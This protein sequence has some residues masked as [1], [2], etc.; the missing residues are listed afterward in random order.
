M[1]RGGLLEIC[2]PTPSYLRHLASDAEYLSPMRFA[3][4]QLRRIIREEA[5][6]A[7]GVSPKVL[8]LIQKVVDVYASITDAD[9]EAL[10]DFGFFDFMKTIKL[11]STSGVYRFKGVI[12][13]D[14][15]DWMS[16]GYA[17]I[18]YVIPLIKAFKSEVM[19]DVDTMEAQLVSWAAKSP[20]GLGIE[21]TAYLLRD[22]AR[23]ISRFIS[24]ARQE[25]EKL[26][27]DAEAE[28]DDPLGRFAF[29][30]ERKGVPYEVNNELEK[31]MR[32]K[33][34][35][36]FGGGQMIDN[37]TLELIR[38]FV[39]QGLYSKVFFETDAPVVYRGMNVKKSGIKWLQ[40]LVGGDLKGHGV[41]NVD[42]EYT[43]RDSSLSELGGASSWTTSKDVPKKFFEKNAAYHIIMHA[44][45]ADN[46]GQFLSAEGL[47]NLSF[48]SPE[49][50]SEKEAIGVG[51]IKVYKI[52]W[53]EVEKKKNK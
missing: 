35:V 28:Q 4:S 29:A 52:E 31:K 13:R 37:E 21:D 24:R 44:R 53:F 36:H 38:G 45:T 34:A 23:G 40:G 26:I 3:E 39:E 9:M 47:Y 15:P 11:P 49:W 46:P 5:R 20:K 14:M 10:Q 33:L 1:E 16:D 48:V 51:T 12:P 7:A 27:S 17:S 42:Y 18:E 22:A 19:P 41:A 30:P 43:Q 8:G 2:F 6:A 25:H 50:K 32:A